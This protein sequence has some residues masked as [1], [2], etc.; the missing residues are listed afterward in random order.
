MWKQFS[1]VLNAEL[2]N[3]Y[4][5]PYKNLGAVF[6]MAYRKLEQEQEDMN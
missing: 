5:P 4:V 2:F 3:D 6:I 1:K